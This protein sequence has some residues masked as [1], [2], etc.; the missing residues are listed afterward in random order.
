[1]KRCDRVYK[2]IVAVADLKVLAYLL[3]CSEKVAREV[4]ALQARNCWMGG[5]AVPGTMCLL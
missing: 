2:L 1:M 3:A 5:T 4:V